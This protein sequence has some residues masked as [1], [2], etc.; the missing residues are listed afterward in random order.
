M[1]EFGANSF[2]PHDWN[3]ASFRTISTAASDV[4]GAAY[5]R[6]ASRIHKEAESKEA[7][8]RERWNLSSWLV[9]EF[10]DDAS[11]PAGLPV[12]YRVFVCGSYVLWIELSFEDLF[13]HRYSATVDQNFKRIE[14]A[15]HALS[16]WSLAPTYMKLPPKPA[17][18]DELIGGARRFGKELNVFCRLDWY[19]DK[20]RG[21]MLGEITLTPN[22][23]NSPLLFKQWANELVRS[24][25]L[26]PDGPAAAG[27]LCIQDDLS[28]LVNNDATPFR[29]TT[30]YQL[31]EQSNYAVLSG[32][33]RAD[34]CAQIAGFN[35]EPWGLRLGARVAIYVPN[36]L[37]AAVV[38]LCTMNKYCA[39]PLNPDEP[40]SAVSERLHR[41]QA[42]CLV[43]RHIG[44]TPRGDAKVAC[45]ADTASVPL[46]KLQPCI[47]PE[48]S[49]QIPPP[50]QSGQPLPT[51]QHL[52]NSGWPVL[53]L[54]TSGTTGQSKAVH[55]SQHRLV[56]SGHALAASLDLS[57]ND[58]GLNMMPLHHVGGICC[59]L[60][61]PLLRKGC[62]VFMTAFDPSS[63]FE[64]IG[65]STLPITWC[66]AVPT[67]WS[68]IMQYMGQLP[69]HQLRVLRSG[70]A[71]L[72][73]LLASELAKKFTCTVL[74]TYS[75]TECMPIASP[76]LTYRLDKPGSVGPA[77]KGVS[78]HVMPLEHKG[79]VGVGEQGEI[80]V[81]GGHCFEGY[82]RSPPLCEDLFRT[83]DL[84]FIDTHGWL[85]ITGRSREVINRGGELIS[86]NKVDEAIV[87]HPGVG[88]QVMTFAAPHDVLGEIVGV[89]V[90]HSSSVGLKQLRRCAES[91]L[92]PASLPQLL[93]LMPSLP[94]VHGT[95]KLQR[96]DFAKAINLPIMQGSKLTTLRY[97]PD[98]TLEER[99]LPPSINQVK[100]ERLLKQAVGV[101][102]A[103]VVD[104]IP[105]DSSQ[106]VVAVT[107]A[108]LNE[109][110]LHEFLCAS[111]PDHDV[112]ARVIP[113]SSIP[114]NRNELLSA[115]HSAMQ[116]DHAALSSQGTSAME[117]QVLNTMQCLMSAA[118]SSFNLDT[119][120]FQAGLDSLSA[121]EIG[122][123]LR[124]SYGTLVPMTLLWER[125]TVREVAAFLTSEKQQDQISSSLI[126]QDQ[127]SSHFIPQALQTIDIET[128][129]TPFEG[130]ALHCHM[131]HGMAAS[132]EVM[133]ALLYTAG[134]AS[135]DSAGI[136]HSKLPGLEFECQDALH[137]VTPKP[138]FYK[139]LHDR[140]WYGRAHYFDWG[141]MEENSDRRLDLVRESLTH[142]EQHLLNIEYPIEAIGGICDGALIGAAVAVQ[143]PQLRLFLNICG[144]PWERLPEPLRCQ[145]VM[146]IRAPSLHLLG[147]ADEMYS[148][149]ELLSLVGRC[150]HVV[151]KRHPQGH[152]IPLLIPTLRKEI[153]GALEASR[154]HFNRSCE[155][156]SLE[157]DSTQEKR[158]DEEFDFDSMALLTIN[159]K[160][161]EWKPPPSMLVSIN[162]Y[163]VLATLVLVH[164]TALRGGLLKGLATT[165]MN[166]L[167]L[168]S[169]S[170][171]SAYVLLAG[172]WDH[173]Q[174]FKWSR[175]QRDLT[176][177]ALLIWLMLYSPLPDIVLNMIARIYGI[178]RSSLEG[179]RSRITAPAWWML[180]IFV[181]R[182]GGLASARAH[183]TR[184]NAILALL[185]HFLSFGTLLPWPF[186][187]SP[188][189]R[190]HNCGILGNIARWLPLAQPPAALTTHWWIYAA[191]P[192]VLPDGF[193]AVLPFE[194]RHSSDVKSF[195]VRA[196]WML[197]AV[198]GW[199][200]SREMF[201]GF[202][203]SPYMCAGSAARNVKE[204]MLYSLDMPLASQWS[205]EA[206]TKDALQ[207][208]VDLT[209]VLGFIAL[210]PRRHVPFLTNAGM[211]N[212]AV[213]FLHVYIT[214]FTD[215]IGQKLLATLTHQLTSNSWV[216]LVFAL[217]FNFSQV[218]LLSLLG[219]TMAR[220]AE[221]VGFTDDG[222]VR[223][224]CARLVSIVFN[225]CK[226]MRSSLLDQ[227]GINTKQ[228]TYR[229]EQAG[230][231]RKNTYREEQA[232]KGTPLRLTLRVA[233]CIC[234]LLL[235]TRPH[236]AHLDVDPKRQSISDGSMLVACRHVRR[237]SNIF[238]KCKSPGMFALTFDD[239]P[240]LATPHIVSALAQLR[241]NAT[242]FVHGK[243]IDEMDLA[244]TRL[245]PVY[246]AGHLIASHGYT[247][248][249]LRFANVKRSLERTEISFRNWLHKHRSRLISGQRS[250][251][252]YL[253]PPMQEIN[254]KTAT[255]VA[256]LGYKVV[257][258]SIETNDWK[259]MTDNVFPHNWKLYDI[260]QLRN[261]GDFT[262]MK[263]QRMS[264]LD[265]VG[266][267]QTNSHIS[268]MHDVPWGVGT[269]NRVA[270]L[271]EIV[272]K[273]QQRGFRF[274]RM[275]ECLGD[276]GHGVDGEDRR[277]QIV[278]TRSRVRFGE[279]LRWFSKHSHG[280]NHGKQNHT[281]MSQKAAWREPP[282]CK[283]S[284]LSNISLSN[285]AH[286][287]SSFLATALECRAERRRFC[288]E[289]V[290]T[291]GLSS[292]RTGDLQFCC[293][294]LPR[295]ARWVHSEKDKQLCKASESRYKCYTNS[296]R[297]WCHAQA[298]MRPLAFLDG[299]LFMGFDRSFCKWHLARL[300]IRT[301]Q[302]HK[303]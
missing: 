287:D 166:A 36:G 132:A 201:S 52:H 239:G 64:A 277:V 91:Q 242:F 3:S 105:L 284:S 43:S 101:L 220:L 147:T 234:V 145:L 272:P 60:I 179:Y 224:I 120:L 172:A 29:D 100:V 85:F 190:I 293:Q 65:S 109:R 138:E 245:K 122:G 4:S 129:L 268:L 119:P 50:A 104:F 110:Q 28:T 7:P 134:W 203:D 67:M 261:D 156:L 225:Q 111:L 266:S 62:M 89:A 46:I 158:F 238:Y 59:N 246:E 88:G 57:Q 227:V 249:D 123:H 69:H 136:W 33:T 55:F 300:G 68:H 152:G 223:L 163:A 131:L 175:L 195:V 185:V 206:A 27:T 219:R 135:K 248:E 217:L 56:L 115:V 125:P 140:G 233:G 48:G 228:N 213:I 259:N 276:T 269:E 9:E 302:R 209:I 61:A 240:T 95:G 8:A 99:L 47:G 24:H 221:R 184:L 231:T 189:H 153:D 229:E 83:G 207:C 205:L 137:C 222:V 252:K 124:N 294:E 93:I 241:V 79:L 191:V 236:K 202:A 186:L 32:W 112:P 168:D 146:R 173:I 31:V 288:F 42:E 118:V 178:G 39:I 290:N 63:W 176:I 256:K 254:V 275:D 258:I 21:P 255:L 301:Q 130:S 196:L 285:I 155:N 194:G 80:T 2:V 1:R 232:G 170:P 54:C 165:K 41:L 53:V 193:P 72:S 35:L 25:W 113:L 15:Q 98:A 44:E 94:R 226:A 161:N 188:L 283:A 148:E 160:D 96:I 303:H 18:W 97:N 187:R 263:G 45:A 86:P 73:H 70:A 171:F 260:S 126:P 49:F 296:K 102:E 230:N 198:Y 142:I 84:G 103:C 251:A 139:A 14:S 292:L 121:I 265:D 38:L 286:L 297:A 150:H 151:L 51:S 17:C 90:L 106:A 10:V 12:D 183:A 107:P 267:A 177:Y 159:G 81:R 22:M 66:Y 75:M 34:L 291:H 200:V 40:A 264:T 271:M 149:A 192:F 164:H 128:T 133:E 270:L 116:H 23:G 16:T 6:Q 247:N 244:G 215:G 19:A 76:P 13:F 169:F 181:W 199:A 174:G 71:H 108:Y 211:G 235:F 253:R 143:H 278:T 11:S 273:L 243:H 58:I 180:A 157:E 77:V 37:Q 141:L 26:G 214:P 237:H 114:W 92:A 127:I 279:C 144:S 208:A 250:L 298:S 216:L 30:I 87:T 154:G 262:Q 280:A 74:P 257:Q 197:A 210:M 5:T 289:A 299:S 282:R 162:M 204:C 212:L 295:A 218:C 117:Q 167:T 274:V 20:A 78:V 281:L 182:L 82:E